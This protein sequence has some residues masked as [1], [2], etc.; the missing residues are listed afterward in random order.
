MI[1]TSGR[2]KFQDAMKLDRVCRRIE[3]S[4]TYYP[5][6]ASGQDD[7]TSV[8]GSGYNYQRRMISSGTIGKGFMDVDISN[9][10]HTPAY[11][12]KL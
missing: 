2:A 4:P 3:T 11:G 9:V 1:Y 12:Q 5:A 6:L 7:A 10:V 8:P